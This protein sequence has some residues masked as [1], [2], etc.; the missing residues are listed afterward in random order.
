MMRDLR[1]HSSPDTSVRDALQG[2]TIARAA[3]SLRRPEPAAPSVAGGGTGHGAWSGF[4]AI[5]IV[6]LLMLGASALATRSWLG[7]ECEPITYAF[8]GSPPPQGLAEFQLAVLEVHDRTG[9]PFAEGAPGRSKLR[10]VWSD[11]PV[12][13]AAPSAMASGEDTTRLLAV[14]GGLWSHAYGG[15]QLLSATIEV[16]ANRSWPLGMHRADGLAAVFV[17]ELGHVMDL[18]HSPDPTSFMYDR[19]AP[20]E[21]RW[22]QHDIE[23]LEKIGRQSGCARR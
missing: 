23:R 5:A 2:F 17:H 6:G 13:L 12:T 16:D 20:T 14:G 18:P 11:G 15:R 1:L 4:V 10:V 9:L 22:T 8:E 21:P 3:G 19:V 7:A